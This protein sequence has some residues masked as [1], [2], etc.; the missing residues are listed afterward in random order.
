MSNVHDIAPQT[1]SC[2]FVFLDHTIIFFFGEFQIIKIHIISCIHHVAE[3]K[4]K[5]QNTMKEFEF[6]L[7]SSNVAT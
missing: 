4:K 7:I 3:G 1:G 6:L 5:T 2:I